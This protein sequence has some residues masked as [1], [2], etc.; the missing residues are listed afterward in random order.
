MCSESPALGDTLSHTR[1]WNVIIV[2]PSSDRGMEAFAH[3]SGLPAT[4]HRVGVAMDHWMAQKCLRTQHQARKLGVNKERTTGRMSRFEEA[5]GLCTV[6]HVI[7]ILQLASLNSRVYD[8]ISSSRARAKF[9]NQLSHMV[10][11][12]SLCRGRKRNQIPIELHT[13]MKEESRILSHPSVTKMNPRSTSSPFT[14]QKENVKHKRSLERK[15]ATVITDAAQTLRAMKTCNQRLWRHTTTRHPTCVSAIYHE[16][17]KA[18][19]AAVHAHKWNTHDGRKT[20]DWP[21]QEEATDI[22]TEKKRA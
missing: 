20:L 3:V 6:G 8:E 7:L 14:S 9:C 10:N 18:T 13:L 2:I 19:L 1:G 16:L 5:Q 15:R 17:N 22:S 21:T 12:M 11:Y 4:T